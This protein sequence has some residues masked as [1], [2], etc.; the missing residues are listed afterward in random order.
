MNPLGDP[1]LSE[2]TSGAPLDPYDPH[3]MMDMIMGSTKYD[4]LDMWQEKLQGFNKVA[5]KFGGI[6]SMIPFG[7]SGSSAGALHRKGS[8]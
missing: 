8:R 6:Q 1:E 3:F 2:Y 4:D 7:S 5:C